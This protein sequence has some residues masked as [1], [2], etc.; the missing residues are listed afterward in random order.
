MP[1]A[2]A[3]DPRSI[4]RHGSAQLPSVEVDSY[5]LEIKDDDGFVG[6][7]A[8]RSSFHDILDRWRKVLQ[9][10]G[11]EDSLG[12]KRAE[13]L[14]KKKLDQILNDGDVHTAAVLHSALEDFAQALVYVV[15]RFMRTKGWKDTEAIVIGGGFSNARAAQIAMAR[16]ELLLRDDGINV[17]L[18]AITHDPDE[19][20]LIGTL[21]LLPSWMIG[22]YDGI[23]AVDIGGTNIRTGIVLSGVK[24]ATDLSKAEVWKS[25][26]WRHANDDPKRD[27]AIERMNG[28]IGDLIAKAEKAKIVLAPVI[29]VGCPGLINEDGSIEAGAQNLPGNWESS[30]F[31]L[32]NEIISAIPQIGGHDTQVIMHNDAVVQGLSALPRMTTY[33]RWG[34]L[35]IGTGLG[36]ARFSLRKKQVKDE[37]Q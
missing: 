27:A 30:R 25:E 28:M 2:Q 4:L 9:D 16:A 13:D 3:K 20:G 35:T 21:H 7:K 12:A 10:A 15:R 22:G 11:V 1:S 18:S 36:N 34:V 31:N 5:N 14:S 26:L 37:E 33:A 17:Q 19:A 32:P 29:G 24:K 6:D 23:V 8:S